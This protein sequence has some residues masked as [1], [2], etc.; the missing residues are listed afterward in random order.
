MTTTETTQQTRSIA[1]K[2]ARFVGHYVE[3]VVAM[4]VG[5]MVFGPLWPA[6]WVARPD[7][8]A[9]TMAADMTIAMALWM[10]VRR[11][12]WPRIVEMCAVMVVPFVV[13]LVP[14]W[15]GVLSGPALMIAGH[16]IMFPL[17]LAAMLWRRSE[18]WH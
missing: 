15:M 14:Y 16:V 7:V 2:L 6:G 4:L 17:M 10:A 9:L 5:M 18:Y 1:P 8:H 13:L 3:M 12:S 11:H